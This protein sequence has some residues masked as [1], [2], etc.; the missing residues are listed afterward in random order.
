MLCLLLV[1]L[2]SPAGLTHALTLAHLISLALSVSQQPSV[3]VA[4]PNDVVSVN[5]TETLLCFP[6]SNWSWLH[7][8]AGLQTWHLN[9]TDDAH[10]NMNNADTRLKNFNYLGS[11]TQ[12]GKHSS[13]QNMAVQEGMITSKAQLET[14]VWPYDP[15]SLQL[16]GKGLSNNRLYKQSLMMRSTLQSWQYHNTSIPQ[17][18]DSDAH[19]GKTIKWTLRTSKGFPRTYSTLLEQSG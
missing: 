10:A 11:S 5:F 7:N 3:H 16:K 14:S 1:C 18:I 9:N 19:S 4:K 17:D 2:Q 8:T 6:L 13:E 15:L 12:G